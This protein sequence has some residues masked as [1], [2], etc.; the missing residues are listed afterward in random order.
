MAEIL[1]KL[2]VRDAVGG[3]AEILKAAQS[4]TETITVDGKQKLA[5]TGKKVPLLQVLGRVSSVKPGESDNGPY[6]KL[7]GMFEGTNLVTGEVFH[8]VSEC[9][10][11]NFVADSIGEA[12]AEGANSV[13]FAVVISVQYDESAVTMYKFSAESKMPARPSDAASAIRAQL[14]EQG[15]VLPGLPAPVAEVQR[16]TKSD[17]GEVP[18]AVKEKTKGKASA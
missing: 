8:N 16:I 2:T 9:I 5:P 6:L 10:L 7:K 12:V 15:I 17:A 13:D 14:L 1:R 18:A 4:G 11:P 3:R